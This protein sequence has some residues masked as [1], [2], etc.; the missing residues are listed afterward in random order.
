MASLALDMSW[1]RPDAFQALWWWKAA[2]R[3]LPGGKSYSWVSARATS[4][5]S[6]WTRLGFY[7]APDW[8]AIPLWT[9]QLA[10]TSAGPQLVAAAPIPCPPLLLSISPLPNIHMERESQTILQTLMGSQ[11]LLRGAGQRPSWT[12][13]SLKGGVVMAPRFS[14]FV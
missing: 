5:P 9:R 14:I 4:S 11:G 8:F 13:N 2:P 7:P 1:Q 3:A 10:A 12:F 6:G